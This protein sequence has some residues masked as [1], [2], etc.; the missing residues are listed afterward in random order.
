ML[1]LKN[2]LSYFEEKQSDDLN[3]RR[4]RQLHEEIRQYLQGI[5]A[6]NRSAF[7]HLLS[8]YLSGRMRERLEASGL[9]RIVICIARP[10]FRLGID[11]EGRFGKHYI[12]LQIEPDSFS[13][14]FYEFGPDE[15]EDCP[16]SSPDQPYD[17]IK[18]LM[19]KLS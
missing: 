14:A 16:L 1:F 8:E 2:W 7:D 17:T 5:P 15:Y 10:D 11:I 3:P 9:N 13:L 6:K 12:N 18:N 19:E 4:N